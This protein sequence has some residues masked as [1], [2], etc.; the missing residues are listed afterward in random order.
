MRLTI[1]LSAIACLS[2]AACASE[3]QP[4]QAELRE[5]H[6]IAADAAQQSHDREAATFAAPASEDAAKP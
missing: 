2:L 6:T 1:A 5:S 3:R 4:S